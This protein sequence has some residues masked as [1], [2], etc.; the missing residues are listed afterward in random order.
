MAPSL[1]N[2][3]K[4]IFEVDIQGIGCESIYLGAYSKEF[5]IENDSDPYLGLNHANV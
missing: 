3:K 4:Y 1:R 5:L 2:R